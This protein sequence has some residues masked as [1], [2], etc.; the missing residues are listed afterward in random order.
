MGVF[1]SGRNHH[2][3]PQS[4]C[5]DTFPLRCTPL[6]MLALV[7]IV[8]YILLCNHKHSQLDTYAGNPLLH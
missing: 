8:S 4:L 5:C 2:S 6:V 3:I 7:L 1:Q